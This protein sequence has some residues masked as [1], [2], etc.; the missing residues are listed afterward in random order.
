MARKRR[1]TVKR[2]KARSA[3]DAAALVEDYKTLGF[4]LLGLL[5][6]F[7]IGMG[8]YLVRD[9]WFQRKTQNVVNAAIDVTGKAGFSVQ[10]ILIEGRNQTRKD[11]VLEALDVQ[12][13]TPI[14]SFDPHAALKRVQDISWVRSGVVERRMPQTIYV[15]L[16]EREPMAIWQTNKQFKLIDRDGHV[17]R[18]MT[19][20]EPRTLP[21]VVGKGADVAAADLLSQLQAQ[22]AVANH[23]KGATRVGER[24]WDLYMND[25]IV[26]KL[27]ED[28]VDDAL[29]RLRHAISDENILE[30]RITGIDLRLPDRM[31][32]QTD[33]VIDPKAE[34]GAK[35]KAN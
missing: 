24:R 21:I 5:G 32:V 29:E 27:P 35:K 9:G 15:R 7:I 2:P 33:E 18:E 25:G 20:N 31:T 10:D 3:P 13:G 14:L 22:K 1:I 30:R 4:V 6:I 23:V 26:V 8:V 16:N 17:L 28:N 11:T 12:K 34:K 19:P